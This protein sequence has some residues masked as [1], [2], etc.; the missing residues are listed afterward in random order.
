MRLLRAIPAAATNYL[1][2]AI[3][4]ITLAANMMP[5]P[6]ANLRSPVTERGMM[7]KIEKS[8]PSISALTAGLLLFFGVVSFGVSSLAVRNG[9]IADSAHPSTT[10]A[11]FAD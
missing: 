9:L 4:S 10:L 2:L 11:A 1:P 5:R 6:T 7:N 3:N 8:E